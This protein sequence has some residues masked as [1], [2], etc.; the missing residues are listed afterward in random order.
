MDGSVLVCV[1]R[2]LHAEN[3]DY[4]T[5]VSGVTRHYVRVARGYGPLATAVHGLVDGGQLIVDVSMPT[6]YTNADMRNHA[7]ALESMLVAAISSR[8]EESTEH[9]PRRIQHKV[10]PL[11]DELDDT[12]WRP[13]LASANLRQGSPMLLL[14]YRDDEMFAARIAAHIDAHG[15]AVDGDEDGAEGDDDEDSD[16]EEEGE[17]EE[18]DE[19]EEGDE[20]EEE[21]KPKP[22]RR[23]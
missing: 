7:M 19:E 6:K 23:R 15:E 14:Q 17:Y 1:Q 11:V 22:K 2:V 8:E 9:V 5:V 12:V 13:A 18:E 10:V 16:D 3:A 21:E 4:D 20:E